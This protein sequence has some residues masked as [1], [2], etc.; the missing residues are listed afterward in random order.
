MQK[1]IYDYIKKYEPVKPSSIKEA[2][3]I[4]E[5]NLYK[6]LKTLLEGERIKKEGSFPN[7][8]YSTT[9]NR[10]KL[11]GDSGVSK[12]DNIGF[13][14][15]SLLLNDN[16][17]YVAADG[18]MMRGVKGFEYWTNKNHLNYE[19]EKNIF[20]RNLKDIEK[21]KK[22]RLIEASKNILSQNNKN[23]KV[24]LDKIYYSDFYNIA[25]FGKTKLGQLVYVGKLAQNI[26]LIR[27]VAYFVKKDILAL[28]ERKNIKSIAFVPPT[29]L[30]KKQFIEI[31]QEKLNI[32]L[33]I[34]KIEK[35]KTKNLIPQ[36]SLKKLDDRIKNA[37]STMSVDPSQKIKESIL[38]VDDATGSGAT[39]NEIAKKIKNISPTTKVYGY[40]I[41]GSQKG[42]DIIN[43]I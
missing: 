32:N 42:F 5:T 18:E 4:S 37:E 41:I 35:V 3:K 33:P 28:I 11:G 9:D 6:N 10:H 8:F 36:K 29:I 26:E 2:I 21:I 38:I 31:F 16:Y 40:S 39:L 24:Y 7:I 43:E 13:D 19:S 27:E 12:S 34:I 23:H 15:D 22:Y 30:R 17:I 25:H 20:I 1:E 14:H